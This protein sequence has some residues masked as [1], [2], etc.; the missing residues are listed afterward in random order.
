MTD[1]GRQ[2]GDGTAVLGLGEEGADTSSSSSSDTSSDTDSDN[3]S[4]AAA[5]QQQEDI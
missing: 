5:G 4:D 3:E 2:N 1:K